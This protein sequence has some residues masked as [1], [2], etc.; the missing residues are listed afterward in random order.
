L[1]V[2]NRRA[3]AGAALSHGYCRLLRHITPGFYPDGQVP[4][5]EPFGTFT[6]VQL[7]QQPTVEGIAALAV[8]GEVDMSNATD[9]REAG[10]KAVTA[11]SVDSLVVDLSAVTF[12]DS[13]GL[14]A[15]VAIRAAAA[16][17]A[18]SLRITNPS[19][20]VR[21]VIEVC[22]LGPEF[23]LDAVDPVPAAD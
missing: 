20:R 1:R 10:E 19:P 15:L 5:Q 4:K 14:G 11:D 7:I 13:S 17:A 6:D 18:R 3:S 12:M 9:L 8:S 16:D 2:Q 23:G 22:G 21:Q